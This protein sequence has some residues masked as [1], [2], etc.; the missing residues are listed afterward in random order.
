MG[1]PLGVKDCPHY[2]E[3]DGWCSETRARPVEN[4]QQVQPPSGPDLRLS[5]GTVSGRDGGEDMGTKRNDFWWPG[6][7]SGSSP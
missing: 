2:S 7:L 3:R 1:A 4:M 5:V 6:L